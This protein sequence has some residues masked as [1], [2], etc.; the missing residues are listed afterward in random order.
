MPYEIRKVEG[1]DAYEVINKDTDEV[2]AVHEPPG[3]KEKAEKQ[4]RL[5]EAVEHDPGWE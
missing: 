4:V 1:S 5:L 2:K 3:A